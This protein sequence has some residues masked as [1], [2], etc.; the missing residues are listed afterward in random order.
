MSSA[1]NLSSYHVAF[2][3]MEP[4]IAAGSDVIGD[5]SYYA[6]HKPARWDI[7]AFSLGDPKSHF[8]KRVLGLPGETIQFTQKGLTI[9]GALVPVPRELRGRFSSFAHHQDH[10][11]GVQP[12]K[13]PADSVFLIG[14][15]QSVY[16]TDSRELG[17][18]PIQNLQARILASVHLT[19][20]S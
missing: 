15:N 4:A 19:S 3:S 13:V 14:D 9:N 8:V 2:D 6:K 5:T 17:P 18:V 7:V 16:V 20:V 11:F 10:K 1:H 12:F